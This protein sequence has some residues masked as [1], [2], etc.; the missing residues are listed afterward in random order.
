MMKVST[1][2][3]PDSVDI[4][5]TLHR[6]ANGGKS[7]K[8]ALSNTVLASLKSHG[9][10]DDSAESAPHFDYSTAPP[11]LNNT[12]KKMPESQ[13]PLIEGDKPYNLYVKGNNE[14]PSLTKKRNPHTGR[15][16]TYK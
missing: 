14:G 6:R 5:Q 9:S 13:D 8:R 15:S 11:V 16:A 7:A 10:T 1:L 3:H 2:S 4:V 12:Q